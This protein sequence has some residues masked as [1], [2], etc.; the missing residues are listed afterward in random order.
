LTILLYS[1]ELSY[2]P[3]K[4]FKILNFYFKM[5]K[6]S[7]SPLR[8]WGVLFIEEYRYG[9][10]IFPREVKF[11]PCMGNPATAYQ[12]LS[13]A[14]ARTG[15]SWCGGPGQKN[16]QEIYPVWGQNF[17]SRGKYS[18]RSGTCQ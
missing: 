10:N 3:L 14:G 2:N 13:L 7:V 11:C 15:R 17:T 6:N 16:L 4:D 9:E 8:S 5:F 1:W 12:H 18:R